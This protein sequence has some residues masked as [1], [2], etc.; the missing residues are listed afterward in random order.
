MKELSDMIDRSLGG[1]V[2]AQ[3]TKAENNV[4]KRLEVLQLLNSLISNN[5]ES[6]E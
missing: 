1:K 5:Q 3:E 6:G 2:I 4:E